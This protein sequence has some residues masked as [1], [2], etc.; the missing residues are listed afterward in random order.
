MPTPERQLRA[1]EMPVRSVRIADEL[2]ARAMARAD[3]D[4]VTMS[5]VIQM[6]VEGYAD[7][8]IELPWVITIYDDKKFREPQITVVERG[9]EGGE[10]GG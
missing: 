5:Y 4:G 8:K 2:W 9:G 1:R 10:E 6:F 3:E 7:R